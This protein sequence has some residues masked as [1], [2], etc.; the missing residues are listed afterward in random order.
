ML[1]LQLKKRQEKKLKFYEN[2]E[3]L[4]EI[5]VTIQTST[6]KKVRNIDVKFYL[7]EVCNNDVEQCNKN[8]KERGTM[9]ENYE[10][11]KNCADT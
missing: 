11:K 1:K 5:T 6:L 2:L 7:F 3:Y 10:Q 9:A 4:Q 8:T